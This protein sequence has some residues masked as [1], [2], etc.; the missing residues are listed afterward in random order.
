MTIVE[1]IRALYEKEADG[2]YSFV[3]K[4]GVS[5][6]MAEDIVQE[7]FCAAIKRAEDLRNHPNPV[8]WLYITVR[9]IM[10]AERRKRKKN[11]ISC[12]LSGLE[13][14]LYDTEAELLLISV[15]EDRIRSVLS[16]KEY[17]I[18]DLIYNQGYKGKEAAKK[19]GVNESTLRVQVLR[20][21]RKL[22]AL[23]EKE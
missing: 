18:L 17:E 15:E 7:T 19:L 2:L 3:T 1:F 5:R 23:V 11:K 22:Q 9:Y 21:R 8:G 4:F 16:K 10:M 13:R 14:Q 12:S 20:I 6:E